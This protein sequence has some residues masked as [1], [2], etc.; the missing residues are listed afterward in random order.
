MQTSIMSPQP[1]CYLTCQLNPTYFRAQIIPPKYPL[2]MFPCTHFY[3]LDR[4]DNL[5]VISETR[6]NKGLQPRHQYHALNMKFLG[7]FTLS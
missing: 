6:L 4:V 5:D 3:P 1:L 2:D 7:Y